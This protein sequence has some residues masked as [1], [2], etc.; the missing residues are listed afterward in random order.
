MRVAVSGCSGHVGRAVVRGLTRRGHTVLGLDCDD[1]AL[2]RLQQGAPELLVAHLDLRAVRSSL[3]ALADFRPEGAIHLA[4]QGVGAGDRDSVPQLTTNVSGTLEFLQVVHEAGGAA[5]VG[6]GSQA[7]FGPYDV[8]LREDLAAWPRTAYGVAKLA[9]GL[10]TQKLAELCGMRHAW[11]R[12][13]ASY[14]P[15]DDRAHLIPGVITALLHGVEPVLT[16]GRQECDYLY[17]DDVADALI[18]TLET[19]TAAGPYVLGSGEA[20]TVRRLCEFVRERMDSKVPLTFGA[21]PYRDDQVMHI[22]AD[23]ARLREATGWFPRTSLE[24]GLT[25]TIDHLRASEEPS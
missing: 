13:T 10:L 6:L 19:G 2:A 8:P 1:G 23:P 5:F 24:D 22:V 15:H 21:V 4:W 9:A 17:V 3:G 18:A 25:L 14:G 12:L 7:E 11:V 16:E 20:V